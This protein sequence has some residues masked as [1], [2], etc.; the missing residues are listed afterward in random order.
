MISKN[1]NCTKCNKSIEYRNKSNL[2]FTCYKNNINYN[3]II[4]PTAIEIQS[5]NDK[6]T[7]NNHI[8]STIIPSIFDQIL[9]DNTSELYNCNICNNEITKKSKTGACQ[10]CY[11][12]SLR[13]VERPSYEI[14]MKEINE[15]GYLQ[16][17]K[18]YGVSDNS[19][20]KWVKNYQKT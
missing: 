6:S 18:K 13:T 8:I 10:P 4:V 20:R 1:K 12:K 2:C 16:T 14:L 11:K 9:P 5:N 19:I 15:N 3:E 17:G 7:L